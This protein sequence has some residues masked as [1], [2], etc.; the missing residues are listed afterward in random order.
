LQWKPTL[1]LGQRVTELRQRAD[2]IL[3]LDA[4]GTTHLSKTV[5]ITAGLARSPANKLTLENIGKFEGRGVYY[6]VKDKAL[7][8][9]KRLLIIGGW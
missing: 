3:E 6:F 9:G 7:F 2:G 8:R 5:L 1:C 4:G